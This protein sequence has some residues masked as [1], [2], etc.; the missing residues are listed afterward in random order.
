MG[1]LTGTSKVQ[2]E[3]KG[4]KSAQVSGAFALKRSQSYIILGHSNSKEC[5]LGAGPVAE[6]VSSR[7]PLWR[8]RV[9]LVWILGAD[10]A[11]LIRPC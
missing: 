7:T 11:P 8:P 1:G 5:S 9:S 2:V 10:M 3:T 6:W 4:L